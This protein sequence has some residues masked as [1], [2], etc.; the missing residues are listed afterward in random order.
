MFLW[1]NLLNLY[2]LWAGVE[3]WRKGAVGG[4]IR[5]DGLKQAWSLKVSEAHDRIELEPAP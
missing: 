2:M 4:A 5:R 1:S 3:Y